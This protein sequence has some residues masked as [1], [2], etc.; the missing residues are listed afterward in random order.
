M[1]KESKPRTTSDILAG[2]FSGFFCGLA[3]QPL[4]V[5]KVNMIILP[6]NYHNYRKKTFIQNFTGVA[7]LIYKQEGIKGFWRGTTPAVI[8]STISSAVYFYVLRKLDA[9][10][11]K[12]YNMETGFDFLN[13]GI[14]RSITALLT[15]PLTIIRTRSELLGSSDYNKFFR[16]CR[17]IYQQEGLKSFYK[18]GLLLLLEEFPFGG[19]FN[20][21]YEYINRKFDF[22]ESHSKIG[23]L[24]SGTVAGIVASTATHPFELCRTKIQSQRVD[25]SRK[26]KNSVILSIMV[27]THERYGY[28][29]FFKGLLPRLLKKT[30][31]NA[32]TFAVYEI[33][34]KREVKK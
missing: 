30:M 32:S 13:S 9:T 3:I 2:G 7:S 12:R 26:V 20:A 21:T 15:N 14:A 1:S 28:M 10:D 27:D 34:R 29:G 18:G 4:E 6:E 17:L 25:F 16:S 22:H 23:Y 8:R 5:L 11:K 19:I 33:I 31:V 24:F